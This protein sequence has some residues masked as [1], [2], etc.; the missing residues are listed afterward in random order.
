MSYAG[1]LSFAAN[2]CARVVKLDSIETIV[3]RRLMSVM[4]IPPLAMFQ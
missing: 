1:G 2:S 3:G 4:K